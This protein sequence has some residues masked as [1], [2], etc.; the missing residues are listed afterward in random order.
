MKKSDTQEEQTND[1]VSFSI[2][3]QTFLSILKHA[4]SRERTVIEFR[5]IEQD[6]ER[7]LDTALDITEHVEHL[8]SEV[9]DG[10]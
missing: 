7:R 9:D 6:G 3:K 5:T 2:D 8:E 4:A 1:T 10:F